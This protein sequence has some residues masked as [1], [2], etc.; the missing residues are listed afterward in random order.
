VHVVVRA[1]ATRLRRRHVGVGLHGVPEFG[2][3]P[4]GEVDEARRRVGIRL[5]P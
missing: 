1:E 5:G 3:E 4:G 2:S